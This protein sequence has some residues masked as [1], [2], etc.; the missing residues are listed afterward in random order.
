MR[1]ALPHW[2]I[3]MDVN[4]IRPGL[5]FRVEINAALK[6]ASVFL[7][8]IGR[9][10]LGTEANRLQRADDP[11]LHEIR[12]ALALG[13]RFV[14]VLAND[15]KMPNPVQLPEEIRSV[16]WFNGV[17]LRNS[18]FEDD[19]QNLVSAVTGEQN[20]AV[21]LSGETSSLRRVGAAIV[22]AL[23]GVAIGLIGLTI[24]FHA[25]GKSASDWL[26]DDGASL[27]LPALA[28]IGGAAGF[29]LRWRRT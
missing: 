11:I 8:L 3:F 12:I 10:W 2:T 5:D 6:R 27:L 4:S 19:F 21:A 28:I 23:L 20:P 15:A 13:L 18:R 24:N 22:G 25:T 9:D 1:Q 16:A 14:P 29:L 7:L 26:G 17:E